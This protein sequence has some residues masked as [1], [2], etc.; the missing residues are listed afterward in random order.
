MLILMSKRCASGHFKISTAAM[1]NEDVS[2][3]WSGYHLIRR[4]VVN[5]NRWQAAAGMGVE[6]VESEAKR[7]YTSLRTSFTDAMGVV[8][9][10]N[11]WQIESTA[12]SS[13]LKVRP[14]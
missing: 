7:A 2:I 14:Y 6:Q 9:G 3:T 13:G 8:A 5:L 10:S 1:G 11:N 4:Q 12:D